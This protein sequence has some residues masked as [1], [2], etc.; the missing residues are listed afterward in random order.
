VVK[1]RGGKVL[2][3]KKHLEA[4]FLF[5]F[6]CVATHAQPTHKG[7]F[8]K[9]RCVVDITTVCGWLLRDPGRDIVAQGCFGLLL[10]VVFCCGR[11]VWSWWVD[12]SVRFSLLF[13]VF[14]CTD[15]LRVEEFLGCV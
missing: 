8:K 3:E 10:L 4:A 2:A 13:Y 12:L 6:C 14:L 9:T 15:T 1:D 11:V 7:I 5:V